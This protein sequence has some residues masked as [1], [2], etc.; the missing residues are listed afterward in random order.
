[1]SESP[2]WCPQIE[3][4]PCSFYGNLPLIC[5]FPELALSTLRGYRAY[6]Y[7]NGVAPWVFGGMTVGTPPCE[8]VLPSPGYAVKPQTT[9]DGPCYVEMF[10]KLWQRTGDQAILLVSITTRT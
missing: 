1:M 6:Q 2:R 9:L 5:F 4:I 7:P 10:D 8:L 3:C